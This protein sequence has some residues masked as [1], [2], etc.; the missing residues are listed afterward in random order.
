MERNKD[1]CCGRGLPMSDLQASNSILMVCTM[2]KLLLEIPQKGGGF[3]GL[4]FVERFHASK[5]D[6]YTSADG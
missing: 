6:Y 4:P 1:G 5:Q 2:M 3:A